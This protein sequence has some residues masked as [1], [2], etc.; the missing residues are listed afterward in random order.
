M[1]SLPSLVAARLTSTVGA[2]R[3]VYT[4]GVPDDPA[5]RYLVVWSNAGLLDSDRAVDVPNRVAGSVWVTSVAR[6]PIGSSSRGQA[7]D[8][9]LWAAVAARGALVGWSPTIGTECH[10]GEHLASSPPQRDESLPGVV[11]YVV[12]QYGFTYQP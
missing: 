10:P 4:N 8:E 7:T 5:D 3:T 12:D 6:H 9:A 1:P 2:A 11:V